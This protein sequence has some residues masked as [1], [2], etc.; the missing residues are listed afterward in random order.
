M[1]GQNIGDISPKTRMYTCISTCKKGIY[2]TH[3]LE[4]GWRKNY[5]M[6]PTDEYITLVKIVKNYRGDE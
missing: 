5:Q 2:E 1:K 3:Q 6:L 4:A